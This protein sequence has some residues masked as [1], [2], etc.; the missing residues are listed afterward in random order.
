M[1]FMNP[2]LIYSSNFISKGFPQLYMHM[3]AQRKK[4]LSGAEAKPKQNWIENFMFLTQVTNE[5]AN[6]NKIF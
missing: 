6:F 3:L 4:I 5:N 1:S 2:H